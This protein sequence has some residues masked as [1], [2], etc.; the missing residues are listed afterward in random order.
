MDEQESIKDLGLTPEHLRQFI[1]RIERLED[2]KKTIADAI[3]DVY[4]EAKSAGFVPA[5]MRQIIRMRKMDKHQ[6]DEE[7]TLLELYRKAL[8]MV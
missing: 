4:Q 3:A 1:E 6:V 5:I 7:E 8:G 2:E